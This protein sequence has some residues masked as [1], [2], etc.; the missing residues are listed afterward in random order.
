[1]KIIIRMQQAKADFTI[2]DKIW[3][4]KN[5]YLLIIQYNQSKEYDVIQF[6]NCRNISES[7]GYAIEDCIADKQPGDIVTEETPIYHS[8]DYDNEMF[9]YG[10]NL[11]AV[12][13][14]YKN[15]TKCKSL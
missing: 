13:L 8:H 5:N 4:N 2:I 10:V 6:S 14:A 1:M 12:Y 7:Y 9:S 11:K 15:L 3:K